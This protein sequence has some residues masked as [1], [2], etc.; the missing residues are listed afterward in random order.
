[1]LYYYNSIDCA[2]P[3]YGVHSLYDGVDLC[4]GMREKEFVGPHSAIRL[5]EDSLQSIHQDTKWM[6]RCVEGLHSKKNTAEI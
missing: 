3:H 4:D 5:F 1:M 2:L 6:S